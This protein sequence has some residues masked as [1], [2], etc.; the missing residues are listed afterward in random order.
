MIS[1]D[2]Q[3]SIV[4][5]SPSLNICIERIM[6]RNTTSAKPKFITNKLLS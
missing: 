4:I 2:A 3:F 6:K 5:Y 1:N